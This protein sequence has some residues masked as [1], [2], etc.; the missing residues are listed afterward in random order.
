M[1]NS[2]KALIKREFWEHKGSIFISPLAIAIILAG[3]MLIEGVFGF[4]QMSH[5]DKGVNYTKDLSSIAVHLENMTEEQTGK[6]IQ[7]ALYAPTLL[8]GGIMLVISLF[9]ALG[10]LYDERKD[11]SILFWKS[12]PISDSATVLSKFVSIC[13]MV[14]VLYF[15]ILALFQIFLLLYATVSAWFM[16]YLG[17]KIWTSSNL[18]SVLFSSFFS[19]MIASL[20]MAPLWGWFMLA[21]SWAKKVPFLWAGAPI[22]IISLAEGWLFNSSNFIHMIGSRIAQGFIIQNSN[23]HLL[24]EGE[25]FDV[26][27]VPWYEILANTEFWLGLIVASLFIIATIYTR[28]YRNES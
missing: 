4:E 2:F 9:Y 5:D 15:G 10:C 17:I 3:L 11:R 14:P 23:I 24:S 19:L 28:R 1:M 6:V 7:L 27:G 8:F 18:L 21:S 25:V 26:S 13:I 22:L 16:G 20:W 12:L